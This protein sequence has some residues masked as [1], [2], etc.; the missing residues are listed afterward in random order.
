MGELAY[1][2]RAG[3]AQVVQIQLATEREQQRVRIRCPLVIDDAGER[4]DAL[5]FTA[6]FFDIA[7]DLGAGQHD[8]GID[9]QAR[10]A[11]GD[12]VFPQIQLIAIVVLAAQEGHARAIRCHL[13]LH[14]RG[15][16]KRQWAGDGLQGEFFGVGHGNGAEHEGKGYEQ[17]A[18]R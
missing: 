14:Q 5:A 18:H 17:G 15:T 11:A 2:G 9:Q 13:G 10:L 6:G 1:R 3:L 12:V 4:G 8:L 16:G 7:Q